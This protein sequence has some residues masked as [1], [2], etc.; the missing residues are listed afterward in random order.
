ML[1]LMAPAPTSAPPT[2]A[3]PTSAPPTSAPP[4]SAPP[5]TNTGPVADTFTT[6]SA[7]WWFV[8]LLSGLLVIAGG[9]ITALIGML[10]AKRSDERKNEFESNRI[11]DQREREDLQRWDRDL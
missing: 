6:S 2:S 9:V 11:L 7:P 1:W 3:P 4:T 5:T 10:S 8:A